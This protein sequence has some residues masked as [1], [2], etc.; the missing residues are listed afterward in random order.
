MEDF[1]SGIDDDLE[2]GVDGGAD[3]G[4]TGSQTDGD[5]S[6]SPSDSTSASDSD[7]R[8]NDLMSKWQ[9]AEAR[10]KKLQSVIDGKDSGTQTSGAP[11]SVKDD[12]KLKAWLDEAA[13]DVAER[14]YRSDP[15]F[16]QYGI[17]AS[18]FRGESP[19]EIRN[20]VKQTRDLIEKMETRIRNAV[21][22]EHG[23]SPEVG[24]TR[25]A[26]QKPFDQ[27]SSKEFNDYLKA[28]GF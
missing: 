27:M 24:S 3:D 19:D 4:A 26:P 11:A 2:D 20:K 17:S 28:Q 18:E 5:Q 12:P 7:K 16:E 1:D 13:A 9:K 23:L 21:L 15:R 25:S 10:A 8:Y 22:S 6:G 14:A